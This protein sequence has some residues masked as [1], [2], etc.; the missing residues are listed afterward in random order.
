MDDTA[1]TTRDTITIGVISDTHGLLRPEAL[2]LLGGV[3]R[4]VHAGDIGS[5]QILDRL[6]A[7]AP[8]TAVRGNNDKG[9]WAE[10]I[11]ETETIEVAGRVI[12]VLH[13]I[14]LIDLDPG[15]AGISV[16]IAGHSHKP[17]IEQR[18]GVLF[19]NPGSIGPRRFRL[20]V[21]MAKLY[22]SATSVHAEIH[23]L[24]LRG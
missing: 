2:S 17:N 5:P 20:P 13:D 22:V 21:A 3:D 16:V 6:R 24:R 12:H 14:A 8:V 15:A 23:E 11:P 4:I 18:D 9:S 19:V 1:T 10:A 7:L